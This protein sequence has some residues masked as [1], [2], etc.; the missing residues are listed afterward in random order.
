MSVKDSALKP[1]YRIYEDR[2]RKGL[3]V[4]ALPNHIGVIHD[5]HRRYARAEGLPDYAAS[6]RVGMAKFVEFLQW[7]ADLDIEAVTCW[8]LS[9]ENLARPQ[10]ELDP[11]Y[12][13]L[14]EM[15]NEIPKSSAG[16]NVKV[17]FIGSLDL[18][19][20]DLVDAAKRLEAECST[21]SRRV[22]IAL[23]Y[24]GRQEI[25]DAVKDLVDDLASS[26]VS[27]SHLAD[28]I[29]ANA[30]SSRMY[31]SDLPDPDLVL[32]T[33]GEARLSGFLLWQAAYAE[34]S[35]VDV[36]WPAF[37]YIDFLRAL[38]DYTRRERRYGK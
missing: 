18:L 32:R 10:E 23:A 15:F 11:Y 2:L 22:T 37:R 38:R 1:I 27:S 33:S 8:L 14:I 35:F 28:H 20:T 13:V 7:T 19:P 34:Y 17:R 26:G 4:D 29:D 24:G 12:A 25:V 9:T 36:Y 5:G 30:M 6:Y 3:N 31:A 21:G 16:E